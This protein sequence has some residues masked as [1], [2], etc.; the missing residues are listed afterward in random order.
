MPCTN[1]WKSTMTAKTPGLPE[2]NAHTEYRT[3]DSAME[4]K[5]VTDRKRTK[6]PNESRVPYN[7]KRKLIR[8][9]AN[10]I[11]ALSSLKKP[12]ITVLYDVTPGGISFLCADPVEMTDSVFMMDILIFDSKTDFEYCI[13]QVGGQLRFRRRVAVPNGT[14]SL[15]RYGVELIEL[16]DFQKRLLHKGYSLI[17]QRC[18]TSWRALPYTLG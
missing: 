12:L 13:T 4:Y 5:R 7:M 10:G 9:R 6:K 8:T 18:Q 15:W 14:L 1:Y 11:V 2:V 3:P 17:H 16:N